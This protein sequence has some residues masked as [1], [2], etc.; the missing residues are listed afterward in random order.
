MDISEM[1]VENIERCLCCDIKGQ[2]I[3]EGVIDHTFGS[4]GLWN[5][6]R[7]SN[8]GHVWLSPRPKESIISNFYKNYYTHAVDAVDSPA[9]TFF[10]G[11]LVVDNFISLFS[12][13]RSK[14]VHWYLEFYMGYR[15]DTAKRTGFVKRIKAI[16]SRYSGAGN[17]A[18]RKV[19]GLRYVPSGKMLDI[20][21]GNGAFLKTMD[22]LGW[23]CVGVENDPVSANIAQKESNAEVYEG[24]LQCAK[25]ESEYFDAISLQHLIEHVYNPHELLLECKRILKCDGKLV[26]VTP[27][28]ESL[29]HSYFKKHWRGLEPPRHINCFSPD[30]LTNTL[31]SAGFEIVELRV[32]NSSL[33]NI[34]YA[35]RLIQS[36]D[37]AIGITNNKIFYFESK[38]FHLLA[39]F[40]GMLF[41]NQGEE[42]VLTVTKNSANL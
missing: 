41:P 26:V 25:F 42:I 24:D 16:A 37:G 4:P 18:Y 38:L 36:A 17:L 6:L 2:V 10:K 12:K 13:L 5:Y 9:K 35:S 11:I 22:K 28:T 29:G 3:Y 34:W 19:L 23:C 30:S 8:C 39:P 33:K 21:C 20:G 40:I 1:Q 32:E 7:C 31:I 15:V 27:N 14:L